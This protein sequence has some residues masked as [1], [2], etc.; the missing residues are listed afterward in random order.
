MC[1]CKGAIST[2]TWTNMLPAV[3]FVTYQLFL[4]EACLMYVRLHSEHV[5]THG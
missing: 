4:T 5:V 3:G 2:G 1:I